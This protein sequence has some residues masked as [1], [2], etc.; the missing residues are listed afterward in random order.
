MKDIVTLVAERRE[1]IGTRAARRVRDT[2]RVPCIVYGH[3]QDPVAITVDGRELDAAVR[4]RA[5]ML[6]LDLDG[7]KD[8]VLVAD[9]QHDMFNRGIV[10]ADF[11]RV[12]MDEVVRVGVPIVMRGK[13]KGE[14]H[15]GVTE[16][17]MAEV[18]V[19]CLPGDIPESVTVVV[20]DLDLGDAIHV[21]DLQ[22]PAGVKVVSPGTQLVVTVAMTR[23]AATETETA[24]PDAE[25]ATAEPEVIAR[26]KA[27]EE[28]EEETK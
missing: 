2:G 17:L 22:V 3:K 14:Q 21:S 23:I 16:Q 26:G 4:Q 8:R 20:A 28:E 10:H 24:A 5:R 7:K 1:T 12:A 9:L 25:A 15:G 6:D 27:E 13:A 19:E 18:E 11:L